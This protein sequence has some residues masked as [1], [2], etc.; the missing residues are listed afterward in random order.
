MEGGREGEKETTHPPTYP[1]HE[2]EEEG[3]EDE[4]GVEVLGFP[5]K[6][7]QTQLEEDGGFREHGEQGEKEGGLI[8]VGE[9]DGWVGKGKEL[10]G[11]VGRR[12]TR[13]WPST[14]RF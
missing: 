8:F 3:P 6:H 4:H 9:V 5:T 1:A 10:G 11:W 12:L 14:L 2:N 7:R 13:A